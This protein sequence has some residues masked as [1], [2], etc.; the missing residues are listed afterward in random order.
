MGVTIHYHGGLDDPAQLDAAL[1]ML[2]EECKRRNW[3]YQ[4]HDF[5][6]RGT[7]ETYSVRS[8]PSDLPGMDD[9]IVETDDVELDTRWRGLIIE[10]HPDSESLALMFD[11]CNGRLMMLMSVDDSHSL[12]YDLSIKTQFAPAE[13]HVA[14]CEV[15]HRLQ[16]E[17]GAANL[18]VNDESG[19]YDDGDLDR[20]LNMR[21]IID[22]AIHNPELIV[23]LTRWATAGNKVE[24][25]DSEQL[26]GRVN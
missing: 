14:V 26:A 7:F 15:L 6:A 19:Y 11:P 22:D 17:F 12:S 10:P 1:A 9:G 3:P 21:K 13:T 24:P 8:V 20:L 25:P 23:R 16:R 5:E 2:R 18:H 4:D